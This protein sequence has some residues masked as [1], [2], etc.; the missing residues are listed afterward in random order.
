MG[1]SGLAGTGVGRQDRPAAVHNP[2]AAKGDGAAVEARDGDAARVDEYVRDIRIYLR[3]KRDWHEF[4]H[5]VACSNDAAELVLLRAAAEDLRNPRVGR[6][7]GA[8]ALALDDLIAAIDARL[9]KPEG[10]GR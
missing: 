10:K 1:A 2:T 7:A 8:R 6:N 3:S 4:L 9:S 5:V